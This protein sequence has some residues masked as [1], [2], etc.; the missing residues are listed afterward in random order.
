MKKKPINQAHT[1]YQCRNAY[2]MRSAPHNPI[3]SECAI[4]HVREVAS[5]PLKCSYFK[6]RMGDA[7]IHSMIPCKL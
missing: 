4:T 7:E 1:C 5:T 2:L 3:V 6:Q